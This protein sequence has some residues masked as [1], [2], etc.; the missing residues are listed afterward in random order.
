MKI[1]VYKTNDRRG[2][3]IWRTVLQVRPPPIAE[4]FGGTTEMSRVNAEQGN[5]TRVIGVRRLILIKH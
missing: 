1:S 4:P 2:G 5:T 3:L